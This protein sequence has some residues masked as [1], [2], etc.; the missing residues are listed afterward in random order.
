MSY[1]R[2]YDAD[3]KDIIGSKAVKGPCIQYLELSQDA[4]YDAKSSA[5]RFD[6]GDMDILPNLYREDSRNVEQVQI[7]V[8][9]SI[10]QS[11]QCFLPLPVRR[12]SVI[13]RRISN[14]VK[15]VGEVELRGPPVL[16]AVQ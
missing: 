9:Q 3:R 8:K 12:G 2:K 5:A 13:Q 6:V 16:I 15:V 1:N 10:R 4:H 14:F 11:R 7:E